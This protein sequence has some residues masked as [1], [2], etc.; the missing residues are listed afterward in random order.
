MFR[1]QMSQISSC[2]EQDYTRLTEKEPV[3]LAHP[4]NQIFAYALTLSYSYI[5]TVLLLYLQ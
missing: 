2:Y 4:N 3:V 5:Y 1:L